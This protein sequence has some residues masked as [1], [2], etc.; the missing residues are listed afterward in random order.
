MLVVFE[1]DIVFYKKENI[2]AE[3]VDH[4]LL[5]RI[6]DF[7]DKNKKINLIKSRNG[8]ISDDKPEEV[9]KK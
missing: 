7:I 6:T 4:P 5:N 3:L 2:K 1:F 8:L 9:K